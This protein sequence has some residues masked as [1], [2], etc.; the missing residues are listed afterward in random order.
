[1][2]ATGTKPDTSLLKIVKHPA[3]TGGSNNNNR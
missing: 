3:I 2:G 1:M